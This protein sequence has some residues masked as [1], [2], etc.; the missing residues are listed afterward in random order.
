MTRTELTRH[1]RQH[2][3]WLSHRS[4]KPMTASGVRR[5]HLIC[6][7]KYGHCGCDPTTLPTLPTK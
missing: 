4:L 7:T 2:Y 6:A 5:A 3:P 1:L